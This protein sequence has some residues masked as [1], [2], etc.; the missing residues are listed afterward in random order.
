MKKISVLLV[1]DEPTLAGIIKDALEAENFIVRTACDGVSGLDMFF[2]SKP[3]IIVSDVMMPRLSGFE[4][5]QKIRRAGEDTPV[6]FLTAKT[7]VDDVVEGFGAGGNDYL[8]KPFGMKELVVR[9]MSLL[10]RIGHASQNDDPV[11][12]YT[13]GHYLFSPAKRLLTYMPDGEQ[14]ELP[15]RENEILKRLCAKRNQLLPAKDILLDLWGDDDFFSTRSFQVLISRL[16][17]RLS[18]DKEI[19]IVNFRGEGYKLICGS[20]D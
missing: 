16:R 18:R 8:R 15:N 4:M 14:T 7:S 6:L 13:I 10:G 20:G 1:E 17:H 3:D 12:E 11:T 19:S 5:V 2:Q 9:I